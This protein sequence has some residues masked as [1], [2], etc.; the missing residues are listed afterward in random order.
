MNDLIVRAVY[1][2][3]VDHMG[4]YTGSEYTLLIREDIIFPLH[5]EHANP[6]PYTVES[7]LRNWDIK[8]V[9]VSRI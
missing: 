7:F 6:C 4:Y 1:K 9:I 5:N 8:E 3:K 2:G